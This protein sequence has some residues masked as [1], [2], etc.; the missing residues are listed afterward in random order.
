M[1]STRCA[2]PLPDVTVKRLLDDFESNVGV[3]EG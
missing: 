2:P 3:F 1:S